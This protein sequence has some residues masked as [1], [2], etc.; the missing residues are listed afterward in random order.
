MK[1]LFGTLLLAAALL[2]PREARAQRVVE[3]QIAPPY[4]RMRQDAETSVLA[5]AYDAEPERLQ[6]SPPDL[7]HDDL[8]MVRRSGGG[9][10]ADAGGPL[11]AARRAPRTRRGHPRLHGA[12]NAGRGAALC[13]L[14]GPWSLSV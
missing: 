10:A 9:G 4:L 5:T 11:A 12:A 8:G 1:K 6:V 14:L 13:H 2:A 3:V 7:D